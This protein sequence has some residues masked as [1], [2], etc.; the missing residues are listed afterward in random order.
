[1]ARRR[2]MTG[3]GRLIIALLIL[4]PIAYFGAAY[5]NGED[6]VAKLKNMISGDDKGTTTISAKNS[7]EEEVS[8][9]KQE[10]VRLE[11]LMKAKDREL[12][13]LRKQISN[14]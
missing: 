9:L 8:E 6:G 10:V 1:M 5:L 12:D 2:K 14:Q 4:A 3:F 13:A 11:E 7:C